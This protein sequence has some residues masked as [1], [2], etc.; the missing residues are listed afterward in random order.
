MP[1]GKYVRTAMRAYQQYGPYAKAAYRGYKLGRKI[2]KSS[3]QNNRTNR[4]RTQSRMYSGV[5][6]QYDVKT[7]YRRKS[8]PRRQ[9]KQWKRAV[10][11]HTAIQLKSVGT[12]SCIRNGEL[13]G[14]QLGSSQYV[15]NIALYGLA[16]REDDP[17]S[18]GF[19]DIYDIASQDTT[20][21]IDEM[22]EKCIFTS[23]V[24]DLTF[25]NTGATKL[26]VDIYSIRV[27][28]ID[29]QH[30]LVRTYEEA[31]AA[32]TNNNAGAAVTLATR[33]WTPFE[34]S[35]A[36]AQGCRVFKKVKHF[37]GAGEVF[38]HQIRDPGNYWFNGAK[39]WRPRLVAEE[40]WNFRKAT[41]CLLIIV[42]NVVGGDPEALGEW[43]IGVTRAYKWKVIEDN[44]DY[45]SRVQ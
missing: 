11:K 33:G 27:K 26:E 23:G 5:T 36:S 24:M 10:R 45:V 9:K 12:R 3:M 1:I 37:V 38:T 32:T 18:I 16:G 13:T 40:N 17:N 41:Q 28:D 30:N 19:R 35:V 39:L 8:M 20:Q 29:V 43:T 15:Q 2:V 25:N 44:K 6:N 42:K 7:I 4:K 34:A 21:Q 22:N 31:L 14:S